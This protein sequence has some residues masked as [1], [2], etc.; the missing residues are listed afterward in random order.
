[1]QW[2]WYLS[3]WSWIQLLM[4]H[5]VTFAC[6]LLLSL[7]IMVLN[8]IKLFKRH[9][10][11]QLLSCFMKFLLIIILFSIN[12]KRSKPT[13][14]NLARSTEF[15]KK[16]KKE[17]LSLICKKVSQFK[18]TANQVTQVKFQDHSFAKLKKLWYVFLTKD[19]P[20]LQSMVKKHCK[21]LQHEAVTL[22]PQNICFSLKK[23]DHI[24]KL[25]DCKII[26]SHRESKA[27]SLL[28]SKP[29]VKRKNNINFQHQYEKSF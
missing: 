25:Q 4:Q 14:S 24:S 29:V 2:L 19:R 12:T 20:H 6:F 16:V 15:F 8:G 3:Y 22:H 17:F 23:L 10:N 7:C 27:F 9:T 21:L 1:M 5:P 13:A 28:S 11:T 18:Y 26:T